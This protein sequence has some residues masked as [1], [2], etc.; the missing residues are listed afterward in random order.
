ML[1][2]NFDSG[3]ADYFIKITALVHVGAYL[4]NLRIKRTSPAC[5]ARFPLD[6]FMRNSEYW[7]AT[8]VPTLCDT[9][10]KLN[11][12]LS[13]AT[14]GDSIEIKREGGRRWSYHAISK[15]PRDAAGFMQSVRHRTVHL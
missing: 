7:F 15:I 5:Y 6:D 13:S 2:E 9:C 4:N 14:Y 3:R 11:K 8:P 1:G 10:D 12:G